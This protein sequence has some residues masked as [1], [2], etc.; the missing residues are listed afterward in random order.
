M[1]EF[2]DVTVKRWVCE[3]PEPSVEVTPWGSWHAEQGARRSTMCSLWNGK[4]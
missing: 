4:L 2:K 1:A 3:E